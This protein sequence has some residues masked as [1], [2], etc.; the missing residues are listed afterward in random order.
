MF[1]DFCFSL[2]TFAVY[3][4]KRLCPGALCLFYRLFS[5][6]SSGV[7]L[8]FRIEYIWQTVTFA[9][10]SEYTHSNSPSEG[11]LFCSSILLGF[12]I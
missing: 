6:I 5:T 9:V 8:N 11:L 2:I 1:T 7:L 3:F 12:Q 4:R 10:P